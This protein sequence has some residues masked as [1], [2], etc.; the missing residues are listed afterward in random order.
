MNSMKLFLRLLAVPAAVSGV[1]RAADKTLIDYFL[2]MHIQGKLTSDVWGATTVGPRDPQNGLEDTTMKQWNYWDGKI[3]KGPDGK[4]HMFASRWDQSR[5]HGAWIRSVA[6]HAV[7]D[8]AMGPYK[9]GDDMA[10]Q[11]GGQGT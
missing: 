7:S 8:H 9:D 6:V 1:S 4:Y 5:G 3:L 2:P 10:G 11:S